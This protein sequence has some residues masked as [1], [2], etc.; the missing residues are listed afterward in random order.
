MPN[1]FRAKLLNKRPT[2]MPYEWRAKFAVECWQS[3]TA[4]AESQIL[5]LELMLRDS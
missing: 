1:R 5:E 3:I 2:Y 4:P